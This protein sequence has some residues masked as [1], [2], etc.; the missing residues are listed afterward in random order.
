M[1]NDSG[2][3]E[4]LYERMAIVETQL[5]QSC[6]DIDSLF[7]VQRKFDEKMDYIVRK[8]TEVDEHLKNGLGM[9]IIKGI[10]EH[11]SKKKQASDRALKWILGIFA[12]VETVS[13][14]LERF[15]GG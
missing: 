4:R 7:E 10:D 6:K 12:V 14:L 1:A 11:L 2:Q 3:S 15:S 5:L 13:F 9:R 8:T